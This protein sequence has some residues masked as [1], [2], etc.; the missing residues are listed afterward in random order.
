MANLVGMPRL[1]DQ[2]FQAALGAGTTLGVILGAFDRSQ[3]LIDRIV[4]LDQRAANNFGGVGGQYELDAHISQG[5]HQLAGRVTGL[6]S[7]PQELP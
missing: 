4:F 1:A 2:L 3:A 6:L 5:F 7:A